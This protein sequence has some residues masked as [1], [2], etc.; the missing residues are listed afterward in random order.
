MSRRERIRI[1][2]K[3][4]EQVSVNHLVGGSSPSRGAHFLPDNYR[5]KRFPLLPRHNTDFLVR[6]MYTIVRS[7]FFKRVE[8]I[9]N[10][11]R[12]IKR[13]ETRVFF[14]YDLNHTEQSVTKKNR[15]SRG[16]T[17][18]GEV[19]NLEDRRKYSLSRRNRLSGVNCLIPFNRLGN[20]MIE[21][22]I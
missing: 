1:N 2:K 14:L 15:P 10:V 3:K 8:T 19:I 22:Y 6:Y 17:L 16:L 20:S 9:R 11:L 21:S 12:L 4:V 18:E 5:A 13:E 7:S